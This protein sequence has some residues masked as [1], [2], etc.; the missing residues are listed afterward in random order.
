[1]PRTK[2]DP[3]TTLP[4]A[5]DFARAFADTA[6]LRDAVPADRVAPPPTD[7]R[8][9]LEVAHALAKT[10][11]DPGVRD[12]FARIP[13]DLFDPARVAALPLALAALEHGRAELD[14]ALAA[15]GDVTLPEELATRAHALRGRML[16]VV[17]HYFEDDDAL[18]AD[19]RA[20]GRKKGH[21]SLAA[22]LLRLADIYDAQR[23]VVERDPKY[24]RAGD[25][26]EARETAKE[27]EALLAAA[28]GESERSWAESVARAWVA[29]ADLHEELRLTGHWLYR[30]EDGA[31][32][33]PAMPAPPRKRGPRTKP[34]E[35]AGDGL[36][37][38]RNGA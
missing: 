37:G 22:D 27:V 1:M 19:V 18:A 4:A 32:R 30:R 2:P 3:A 36:T 28:R 7:L 34:E 11:E 38:S 5:A 35:P 25:A 15:R 23:A 13:R 29:L 17:I 9:A 21:A 8:P 10:L 6:A 14:A 24:W 12:R 20:L 26:A 31:V 33:F 16:K